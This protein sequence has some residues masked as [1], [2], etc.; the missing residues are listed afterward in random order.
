MGLLNKVFGEDEDEE[1]DE[2]P[3]DDEFEQED[4]FEEEQFEE[5]EDE[6]ELEWESAYAFAEDML[7][8]DGFADM[9]EF[10]LKCMMYEINKSPM[11]RDRIKNGVE[12]MDMVTDSFSRMEDLRGSRQDDMGYSEFADEVK[13]AREVSEELDKLGGKEDAMVQEALGIGSELVDVLKQRAQGG[14]AHDVETSVE[15]TE[16]EI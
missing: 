11:Y 14:A 12:T 4:N 8:A 13:A 7:E 2:N 15:H 5:E 3:F 6:E 16:E 10:I 9:E 1:M